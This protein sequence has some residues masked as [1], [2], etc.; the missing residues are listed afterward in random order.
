MY[1]W[2]FPCLCCASVRELKELS[3]GDTK[4]EEAPPTEEMQV[5]PPMVEMQEVQPGLTETP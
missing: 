1:Q 2:S 4:D 3:S 5:T